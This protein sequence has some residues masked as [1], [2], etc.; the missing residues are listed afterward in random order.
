M[1]RLLYIKTC[2]EWVERE[3]SVDSSSLE[4]G[5]HNEVVWSVDPERVVAE[6]LSENAVALLKLETFS[7]SSISLRSLYL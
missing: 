7:L 6:P 3:C 4:N 5:F 1:W 2:G